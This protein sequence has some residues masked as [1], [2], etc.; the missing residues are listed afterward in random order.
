MGH[1]KARSRKPATKTSLQLE[2]HQIIMRPLVTEKGMQQSTDHNQYSFEVNMLADKTQIRSA[3]EE[4]FEVE[5]EKVRIQK[6]LGKQ[7]RHKFKQGT[8]KNWK[9][10][11]VTLKPEFRIDFF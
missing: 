1:V 9:K 5:V 7:R 8:T 6:R 4:L 2:A 3:V 11:I 10:A